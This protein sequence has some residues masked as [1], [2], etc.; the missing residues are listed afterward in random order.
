MAIL[1][2]ILFYY[3]YK[4]IANLLRANIANLASLKTKEKGNLEDI[5]QK[6]ELFLFPYNDHLFSSG[7]FLP[8]GHPFVALTTPHRY[9]AGQ[10]KSTTCIL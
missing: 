1:Y 7:F 4:K 9:A 10:L 6:R 5:V 3:F 8:A 2:K